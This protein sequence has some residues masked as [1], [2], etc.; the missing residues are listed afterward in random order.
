[1]PRR[2]D[3]PARESIPLFIARHL[4]QLI[5][6]LYF[7]LRLVG[8]DRIPRHGPVLL[9]GNH[10]G[11]LD[12]PIVMI[13]LPRPS[14]FLAKSELYKGPL[15]QVLAFAR[16]IPIHRGT[17]DR[18]NLKAGLS[19]LEGRGVLGVF[20]EGTRGSGELASIQHGIGYIA[21]HA[22]CPIVP[23]VCTGTAAALP[24]GKALPKFRAPIQVVF[25]Q[26]F[27]LDVPGDPRVRATIA[28]AAE[29]IRQ[30]LLEHLAEVDASTSTA[31]RP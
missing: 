24:K 8:M 2:R 4:A 17:P 10:S 16:Q 23:V 13:M 19:V 6:R 27:T 14:S 21:L 11:F 28:D 5:L 20:P 12:G 7:R 29:Q 25:G 3:D 31:R 18:T 22:R 30:R 1:M 15:R 9:A 26:P